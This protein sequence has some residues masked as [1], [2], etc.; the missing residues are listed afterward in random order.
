MIDLHNEN[1]VREISLLIIDKN[2]WLLMDK[3]RGLLNQLYKW[4]MK[5]I[6]NM[7][8]EPHGT[9]FPGFLEISFCKTQIHRVLLCI[10]IFSAGSRLQEFHE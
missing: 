4:I 8:I 9:C 1:D 10:E 2:E 6:M 3:D 7:N 5:H